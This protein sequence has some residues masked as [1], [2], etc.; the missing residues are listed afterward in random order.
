MISTLH[1]LRPWWFLALLPFFYLFFCHCRERHRAGA[2]EKACDPELLSHLVVNPK[3]AKHQWSLVFIVLTGL[4]TI[5]ALCGPSVKSIPAPVYSINDARVIALDLS[6]TLN[7][8]DLV[9]SRLVRARYK[10]LD[11]LKQAEGQTGLV[12]FT[13][14]AY[15]VSPLTRDTN[16][17][18]AMVNDLSPEIMPVT[19]E[20]IQAALVQAKSLFQQSGQSRGSVILVT[21]ADPTS[22]DLA[23]AKQMNQDGFKI[24]VLGVGTPKGSA[25]PTSNGYLKN[26]DDQLAW[27]TLN[28]TALSTLAAA[29][30]GVY[31]TITDND[32]DVRALLNTNH[33]QTE[34]KK[35]NES[36]DIFIDAGIWF[37]FLL[38]PL[39]LLVLRRGW[40]EELIR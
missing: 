15:T 6:P 22:D 18:A 1:F 26:D 34:T 37:V 3:Q 25:I 24:S 17:M 12:A 16:T 36:A 10:V 20:S 5:L 7:A 38:L 30:G 40:L 39:M 33:S 11:L 19:G 8:T 28:E 4:F 31:R 32:A 14:E 21:D 27:S 35:T 9:P 13:S 2:W 29:G 23:M